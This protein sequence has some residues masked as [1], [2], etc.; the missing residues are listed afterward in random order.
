MTQKPDGRSQRSLDQKR[1]GMK[2][3]LLS[4]IFLSVCLPQFV[5]AQETLAVLP[6][7]G[8]SVDASTRETV[9]MLLL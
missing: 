6:L 2:K 5:F 4:I 3:V 9:Y 8:N 7:N 1:F